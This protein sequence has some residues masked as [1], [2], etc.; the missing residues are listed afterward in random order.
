[1]GAGARFPRLLNHRHSLLGVNLSCDSRDRWGRSCRGSAVASL[2]GGPAPTRA[3][4]HHHPETIFPLKHLC[5]YAFLKKKF[6]FF[7]LL[8]FSGVATAPGRDAGGLY[9]GSVG[10]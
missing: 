2:P 6:F 1:M 5:A 4:S 8:C 10:V 7:S 3:G 9:R